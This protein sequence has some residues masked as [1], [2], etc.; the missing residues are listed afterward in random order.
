[1][2]LA[3]C[4]RWLLVAFCAALIS[5]AILIYSLPVAIGAGLDLVALVAHVL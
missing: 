5:P 3:R 2:R 4:T 1:M